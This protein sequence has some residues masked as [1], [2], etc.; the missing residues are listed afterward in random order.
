MGAGSRVAVSV[1]SG[2][3]MRR[4]YKEPSAASST[5]MVPRLRA[6][7]FLDF[8][9]RPTFTMLPLPTPFQQYLRHSQRKSSITREEEAPLRGT[10]P[11]SFNSDLT[12]CASQPLREAVGAVATGLF[13]SPSLDRNG[14]D[15]AVGTVMR[16]GFQARLEIL[17]KHHRIGAKVV[18]VDVRIAEVALLMQS[19]SSDAA[20]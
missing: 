7:H 19:V 1:W 18:R 5:A 6:R 20:Q 11:T 17:K 2:V 16:Q 13:P 12:G 8:L 10:L 4:V 9:S 3:L 14:L 15:V